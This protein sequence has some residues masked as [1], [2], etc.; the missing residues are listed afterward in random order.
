MKKIYVLESGVTTTT[1]ATQAFFEKVNH[2]YVRILTEKNNAAR[3][4]ALFINVE[5]EKEMLLTSHI[6]HHQKY[7]NGYEIIKTNNSTIQLWW[8]NQPEPL[9][10]TVAK[11]HTSCYGGEKYDIFTFNKEIDLSTFKKILEKEGYQMIAKPCPY[12][13]CPETVRI[14][15]RGYF[16]SVDE[17]CALVKSKEWVYQWR[18][19]W[20][21]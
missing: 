21:D 5:D 18:G 10:W 20:S 2:F 14:G 12:P 1:P 6:I 16:G 17:D 11:N 3:L 15:L 7:D 9:K 13:I 8:N 4:H 19:E